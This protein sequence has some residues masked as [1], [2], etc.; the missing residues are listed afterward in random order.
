MTVAQKLRYVFLLGRPGCGK[1][2]VFRALA[3][4]FESAGLAADFERLDDF[5]KLW[6]RIMEDDQR[7]SEGKERQCSAVDPEGRY[8]VTDH[9]V[10]DEILVEL[11]RD[12]EEG[13]REG[14]I[15]FIEFARGSYVR[16]L[17]S[18]SARVLDAAVIV[19]IECPFEV[20]WDRNVRRAEAAAHQGTDDHLVPREDMERIYR[21]DDS[22]KLERQ[23]PGSV[24]VISNEREGEQFLGQQADK[25][26]DV[27]RSRM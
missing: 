13:T 10:F 27:I 20:C 16:A 14:K 17:R 9:R 8:L 18:F 25:V 11:S 21:H 5:P 4:K 7:A 1:S 6:D 15:I 2:A 12:V 24:V 23:Y 19:Y 3:T 26:L 22:S